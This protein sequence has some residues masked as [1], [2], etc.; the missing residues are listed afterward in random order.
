[1]SVSP[2]DMQNAE[3]P[4][5]VPFILPFIYLALCI[6]ARVCIVL[7]AIRALS[8]YMHGELFVYCQQSKAKQAFKFCRAC[9]ISW[10]TED[11]CNETVYNWRVIE[12]L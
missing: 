7:V 5:Y 3:S 6:M 10:S 9:E 1:M 8:V 4:D 2:H 11:K 12:T